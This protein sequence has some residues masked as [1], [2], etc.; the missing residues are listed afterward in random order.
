MAQK[1]SIRDKVSIVGVGCCQFGENWDQSPSDMIVDDPARYASF[2]A[3]AAAR[4]SRAEFW[5][6]VALLRSSCARR[7]GWSRERLRFRIDVCYRFSK[8]K[9]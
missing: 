2:D 4:E 3:R 5:R 1:E 7:G 8:T 6:L 9:A